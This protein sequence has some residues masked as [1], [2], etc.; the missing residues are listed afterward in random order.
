MGC[1]AGAF[2][3]SSNFGKISVNLLINPKG[4]GRPYLPALLDGKKI[5]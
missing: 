2:W 5:Y 4:V 1:G 3:F